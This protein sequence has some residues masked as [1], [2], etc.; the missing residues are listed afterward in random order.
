MRITK[1]KLHNPS[2]DRIIHAQTY[3]QNKQKL[4]DKARMKQNKTAAAAAAEADFL[5]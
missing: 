2:R 5:F 4:N 1:Y 3:I